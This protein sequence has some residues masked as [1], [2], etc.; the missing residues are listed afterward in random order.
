MA[1]IN[2]DIKAGQIYKVITGIPGKTGVVYTLDRRTGQFLWARPTIKQD[3]VES[4]DGRTGAV[5]IAGEVAVHRE[6]RQGRPSAPAP[7]AAR[8]GPPAP[9][10]R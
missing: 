5:K 2:P 1:W 8:T 9:T 10:A 4:I 3:A 6:G 7:P